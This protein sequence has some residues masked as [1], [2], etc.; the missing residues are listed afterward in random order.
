MNTVDIVT[1]QGQIGMIEQLG[2]W[3]KEVKNHPAPRFLGNLEII[4]GGDEECTEHIDSI[5]MR[6]TAGWLSQNKN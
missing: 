1:V 2:K 4:D 5:W 3:W 6:T